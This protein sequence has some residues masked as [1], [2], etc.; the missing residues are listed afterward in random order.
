MSTT[1]SENF[2][3][4]PKRGRP[5][6]WMY[7]AVARKYRREFGIYARDLTERGRQNKDRR[8]SALRVILEAKDAR[9]NWL[10]DDAAI[11]AGKQ[12][13]LPETILTELGRIDDDHE[14]LT[15]ALRLCE[16]RPS[17]REAV[18]MIREWRGTATRA[19]SAVALTKILARAID[20]YLLRHPETTQQQVAAAVENL[21]E[22]VADQ[23]R[24]GAADA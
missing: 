6:G 10:V 14:L 5:P 7:G 9:L 21:V 17:A 15:A 24:G 18:A 2:S 19:P 16:L 23:D 11:A 22:I 8:Q 12:P 13:K 4:K 20:T 3:E 1:F